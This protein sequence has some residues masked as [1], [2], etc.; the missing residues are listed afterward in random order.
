M[1]K[2][3]WLKTHRP[4][5]YRDASSRYYDLADYLSLRLAGRDGRDSESGS[6]RSI[7]CVGAKWCYDTAV[8]RW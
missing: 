4:D 2:L 1:P 8:G 5:I 3:R 7:C 6:A